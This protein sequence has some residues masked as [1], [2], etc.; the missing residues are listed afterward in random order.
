MHGKIALSYIRGRLWVELLRLLP[1]YLGYLTFGAR[2]SLCFPVVI[3]V[4]I[5][6]DGPN[7]EDT[8]P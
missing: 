5:A 3:C 4:D 2:T 1:S 6:K 8:F 7:G